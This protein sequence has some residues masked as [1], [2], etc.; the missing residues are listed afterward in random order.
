MSNQY[1][2]FAKM[3]MKGTGRPMIQPAT[4]TSF[5]PIR[6]EARAAK[7]LQIA[8]V[9]PK[10]TMN[11]MIAAFETRPNSRSPISGT[12]VRSSPTIMPT[13]TLISTSRENCPAFSRRPSR[14]LPTFSCAA[15]GSPAVWRLF[16]TKIDCPNFGCFRRRRRDVLQ[17][18]LYE[19]VFV[20][21]PECSVELLLKPDG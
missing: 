16:H 3:M 13:K 10:L 6:S 2:C 9:T 14:I 19:L 12:T 21:D 4:S 20:H 5:R 17:H 18:V 8:L 15:D 1:Q 7:R 11:E